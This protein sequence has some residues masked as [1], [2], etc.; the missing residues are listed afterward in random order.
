[1][2]SEKVTLGQRIGIIVLYLLNSLLLG[3]GLALIFISL[4]AEHISFFML[5]IIMIIVASILFVE[6]GRT[7]ASKEWK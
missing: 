5:S 3:V 6:L 2:I 4:Y 1:M 7:K